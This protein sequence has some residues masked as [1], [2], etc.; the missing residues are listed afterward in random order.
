V[1]E[2]Y[3]ALVPA[4]QA[5]RAADPLVR[6]AMAAIAADELRHAALALAVDRWSAGKMPAAARRRVVELRHGAA[7]A[8]ATDVSRPVP[9]VVARIAGL[10][11]PEAARRLAQATG[12]L[13]EAA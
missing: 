6:R 11:A 1:R 13:A 8:L 9:R 7:A 12:S 10:P 4:H 2:A 5:R 3:G